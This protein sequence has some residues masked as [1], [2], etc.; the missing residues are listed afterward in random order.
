MQ[1]RNI[2]TMTKY[3]HGALD[4]RRPEQ[5]SCDIRETF[6]VSGRQMAK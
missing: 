4:I 1:Y 2:V 6:H 5:I 3:G